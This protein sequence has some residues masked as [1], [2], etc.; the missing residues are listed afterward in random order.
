M[1]S[2]VTMTREVARGGR[3]PK[4]VGRDV[5]RQ[6]LDHALRLFARRGYAGTSIRQIADAVGVSN[7]ALYA[8]FENKQSIYLELMREGGPPVATAVIESMD[9]DAAEPRTF[10]T[11]AVHAVWQAWDS[12]RERQFLSLALREGVGGDDGE[13]PQVSAAVDQLRSRLG[14]IFDRW[15]QSGVMARQPV[16]GEHLAF[17]LFGLVALTRILYLNETSTPAE[18]ATGRYIVDQHLTFFLDHVFKERNTS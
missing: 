3:P 2:F 14:P 10:L 18:R 17:E 5:R 7:P 8:H 15:V 4:A 9:P 11:A 16:G 13:I 6:I 1:L 12:P